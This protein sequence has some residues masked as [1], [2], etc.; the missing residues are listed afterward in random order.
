LEPK[1]G[2]QVGSVFDSMACVEPAG[3]FADSENEAIPNH[4][5][6]LK[7]LLDEA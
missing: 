4:I 6:E 3:I 2:A 7:G 5:S 1:N